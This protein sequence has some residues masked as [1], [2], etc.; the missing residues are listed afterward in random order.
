MEQDSDLE[1]RN[2][3]HLPVSFEHLDTLPMDQAVKFQKE[4]IGQ[5]IESKLN[6]NSQNTESLR[7]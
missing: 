2:S 3:E 4:K 7:M 6:V 5:F 1:V